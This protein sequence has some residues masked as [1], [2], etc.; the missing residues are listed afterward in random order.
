MTTVLTYPISQHVSGSTGGFLP[1]GGTAKTIIFPDVLKNVSFIDFT[2]MKYGSN[3]SSTI[4]NTTKNYTGNFVVYVYDENN[5]LIV[6]KKIFLGR[7]VKRNI[8]IIGLLQTNGSN[9]KKIQM[10]AITRNAN[11]AMA[12]DESSE[13][14]ITVTRDPAF[15][16]STTS[17]SATRANIEW[18]SNIVDFNYRLVN[19]VSNAYRN[20]ANN[21]DV[22]VSENISGSSATITGMNPE[23]S[24]TLVLQKLGT[25]WY[26]VSQIN[27]S[28]I[29]IKIYVEDVGSTYVSL[30]WDEYNPGTTYEVIATSSSNTVSTT[31][32]DT[33]TIL[34]DLDPELTYSLQ[35]RTIG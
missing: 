5:R 7:L 13:Y 25:G 8:N 3:I 22:I 28:T 27:F 20:I 14:E 17:I 32:S 24:Y 15:A 1:G 16:L 19:R 33:E 34:Q 30:S 18:G 2:K 35:L 6:S 29:S 31:T 12:I 23:T 10:R 11:V 9:V 21:N 26:D 4:R